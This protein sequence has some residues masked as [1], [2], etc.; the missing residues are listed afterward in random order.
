VQN[1][2]VNLLCQEIED[3]K[4]SDKVV[5]IFL[6]GG[7]PSLLSEDNI[8]KI[9][10]KIYSCYNVEK[11]AEITIEV[12]PNSVSQTKLKVYKQ[13]GI[14]RISVGV[15]SLNDG[16][17]QILGRLHSSSQAL[18]ALKLIKEEGFE[19]VNVDVMFGVVKLTKQEIEE[20]INNLFPYVK[21]IS[22]YMLILEENTPLF[23]L[24]KR[25]EVCLPSEEET[26]KQ[27]EIARKC[28]QKLGLKRYELSNYA[29]KGFESAHNSRYWNFSNYFGFGISAHSFYNDKRFWN[30][31]NFNDYKL[32][33][34]N[35]SKNLEKEELSIKE[36]KE[37]FIMLSL[38]LKDG[39]NIQRYKDVFNQDL[40]EDKK[41]QI[42]L[43]VNN[44]LIKVSRS[45]LKPTE[46]GLKIL[47]Q[48]I[49]KLI[50]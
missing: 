23:N 34:K 31:S 18:D 27:Y 5:S 37:E 25:K 40:L 20:Q 19:N 7:T 41:E 48:I 46:K 11:N 24:V 4:T 15:Q 16:V 13:V 9:F 10:D 21:H 2:Y 45:N 6:G 36:K 12:N 29:L 28:I 3:R 43:L 35:K 30:P 33:I 22:T 32:L 50:D 44:K 14:N 39:I 42:N 8:K 49:L 1:D 26:I 17:L 38:R 47:N